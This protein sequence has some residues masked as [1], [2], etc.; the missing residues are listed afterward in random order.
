MNFNET[1]LFGLNHQSN[2]FIALL[3]SLA[4]SVPKMDDEDEESD[5][6]SSA[7]QCV[8]LL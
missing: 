1:G 3:A 7:N 8:C 4:V 2:T 6:D 5:T